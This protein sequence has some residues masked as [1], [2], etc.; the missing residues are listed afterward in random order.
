MTPLCAGKRMLEMSPI[1]F[2]YYLGF[3]LEI[4]CGLEQE[5]LFQSYRSKVLKY[6][7]IPALIVLFFT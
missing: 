3:G 6:G 1:E 2:R 5:S 7:F 4:L